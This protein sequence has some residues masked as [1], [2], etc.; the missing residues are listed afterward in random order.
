MRTTSPRNLY[1]TNRADGTTSVCFYWNAKRRLLAATTINKGK[2]DWFRVEGCLLEI[3]NRDGRKINLE[4]D[5]C[6]RLL[7]FLRKNLI[8]AI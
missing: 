8:S 4:G 6:P 1:I 2:E 5:P 7:E 3:Y